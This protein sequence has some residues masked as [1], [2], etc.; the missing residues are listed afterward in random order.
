MKLGILLALS[1]LVVTQ[2][3]HISEVVPEPTGAPQPLEKRY[4]DVVVNPKY[5][6]QQEAKTASKTTSA[7]QPKPWI[8]T[9]ASDKKEIVTPTVIASVTFGAK[10]PKTTNGLEP[11]ISLNKNGSP[12]TIQP[13]I[14]NGIIKNGSPTYGTW[15]ATATTVT[16]NKE[17]LKAHNMADDEIFEEEQHI[18]EDP[19]EHSLNPLLRC[20]PDFYSK[21][22]VA[23]DKT[24]EPFCFPQD[25]QMLNMGKTYFVTWYSNFFKDAQNVK[26]HLSFVKESAYHRGTKRDIEVEEIHEKRSV[27]LDKGG[28]L[29][30]ASF[31]SSE[32][33]PRTKGWF[34]ITIDESWFGEGVNEAYKKVL[35]SIQPD[36]VAD[37]DFDFLKNPVVVE[38]AK[39]AKVSKEGYKDL[40]LMYDKVDNQ[41]ISVEVDEG[42]DE[43]YYVIIGMPT[44][45]LI[46]A[47]LMYFFVY[48]NK[49][50][51]DL[52]HLRKVKFAKNRSKKRLLFKK[53]NKDYAE[54]PQ[55]NNDIEL[56]KN[57]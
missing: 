48:I 52:S 3:A 20:T 31:F 35:I 51:T 46:A 22:G 27:V 29:G 40:K 39:G 9:L 26:V 50:Y 30:Q 5:K 37:E 41:H 10:P 21:R 33:L 4:K 24:S 34:P 2:A 45:V 44:A 7:N 12:K 53:K 28:T 42:I 38:I 1:S 16:Y 18:E 15:F 19:Y 55:F 36:N 13:K 11:W 49:G 6:E 25:N 14:K 8:R 43:K 57:D 47:V 54:L 32:W 17:E 56:T 23:K